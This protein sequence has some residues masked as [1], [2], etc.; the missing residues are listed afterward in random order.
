MNHHQRF[1]LIFLC[2]ASALL[3]GPS[4]KR[5]VPQQKATPPPVAYQPQGWSFDIGGSYSWMSFSTPPTYTGSTGGVLGKITYQV[6][7]SFF[8]QARSYYN[9]GP[10]SSST[11]HMSF[12]ESYS[13]FVGGYCVTAVTNWTITPY[14]GLGF[15]FLFDDRTGYGSIAP[16]DLQY[17]IYYAIVGLET[18]YVWPNWTLGLRLDCLPTFNQYL[19]IE[20]L[21]EAA[22]VLKNRVG[23]AVQLPFAYRYIRNY[24][25]EFAPYYRFFPIGASSALDLPDRDLNQWGLFVTL[26]FFL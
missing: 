11:N 1:V 13:E 5:A 4:L 8:G 24:W 22:W 21:S 7:D 23:V 19:R 12:Q 15:D 20:T 18:H 6:P 2:V 25:L 26:R 16:I 17:T 14:A 3:G 10:L 9:I